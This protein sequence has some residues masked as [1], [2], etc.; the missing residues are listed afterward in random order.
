M[1]DEIQKDVDAAFE[2]IQSALCESQK[3]CLEMLACPVGMTP[4]AWDMRS[5]ASLVEEC[6][7]G[8]ENILKWIAVEAGRPIPK[9]ERWHADLLNQSSETW[10]PFKPVI[11]MDLHARLHRML[12]FR[13]VHRNSYSHMLDWPRLRPHVMELSSVIEAFQVAINLFLADLQ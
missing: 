7:S 9:T 8:V 12:E 1:W 11:S 3:K 5:A 10:G 4:D 6:Y 13:H 2:D